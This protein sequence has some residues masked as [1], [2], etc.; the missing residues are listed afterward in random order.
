MCENEKIMG[1]Y[2]GRF[3]SHVGL[4]EKRVGKGGLC[5]R[6]GLKGSLSIYSYVCTVYVHTCKPRGCVVA[7]WIRLL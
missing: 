1:I 5:A 4:I 6:K 7:A 3:C 2:L